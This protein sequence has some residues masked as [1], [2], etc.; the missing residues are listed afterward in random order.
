MSC[1]ARD[2][3]GNS[4]RNNGPLCEYHIYM[5][6]Y[7]PDM[8]TN[9]TVCIGCKKMKYLIHTTCE[10]CRTHDK[11]NPQ[12]VLCAK[13]DCTFKKSKMNKYCGKHQL[14]LFIDETTQLGLKCCT[15]VVRGC[16]SQIRVT[17]YNKCEPCL[18]LDREKDHNKRKGTIVKTE[19]EKQCSVCC[20]VQPIELFQGKLGETK[21][22][23]SCREANKRADE[24]REKEHVRELANQNAMKPE[25]KLVKRAWN[26]ANYEKVASY[27]L[28]SRSRLIESNLE[29]FLKRNAEQAKHWRDTNPEKV[30]IINQQRNENIDYHFV[31]Y[32]RTANTKQLEFTLTKGDFMEMVI[33]PCYYCGIVQPKGFNGIDRLLSTDGYTLNNVVSCCE[34]CNMMKK[35]SSPSVFVNRATHISVYNK[36]T[37]GQIYPEC[38]IDINNVNYNKY[39]CCAEDKKLE[40]LIT[41]NYFD[42]KIKEQ[43]YLCGKFPS[44]T[45][46]NGLDR[47][48]SSIGY[49]ETNLQSCCGNCNYMKTNYPLNLFLDKCELISKYYL[50]RYRVIEPI[51][52]LK[53]IVKGN[54]LTLEEKKEKNRIRRQKQRDALRKKY[55]DEEYK[56]LHA[57]QI[58]EQRMKKNN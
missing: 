54:K 6:D 28:E 51:Q 38:F 44:Q 42:E 35:C 39:K 20:K 5:K 37:E 41:K 19:T 48:D 25:R 11:P 57:K 14:Y 30:K 58:A 3:H 15:N 56:K 18:K 33:L 26:E 21:T 8:I 22:C 34:M 16:R 43:C 9:S 50:S 7:T 36:R 12:I 31:N 32:K 49:I 1:I 2:I 40:F 52:E 24:K 55:G 17:A 29:G 47:V 23:L 4:C 13:Q 45:H 46:K 53:Q 27:W 10:E